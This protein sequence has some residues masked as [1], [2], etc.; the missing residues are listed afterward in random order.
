MTRDN[1]LIITAAICGAEV[2]KEHTPHIPYTAE[3]LASEAER[4]VAAGA[5][6]IHLHVREDDGTPSQDRELFRKAID[7]IRERVGLEP[8]VQVSTGGAVGMSVEER[9]Q[10]LALRPDMAT[11]TTGTVNFGDDVFLND[12][13]SIEAI[14][15][16]IQANHVV[17]E[18]EVFD[19]GMVDTS[20]RLIKMGKLTPPLHYDFVMGVPGGMGGTPD[21]LDFV[22]SLI[23]DNCTWTVAGIGRYE[24]PL[25]RKA[26]AEGGHVRVG[27]EDNIFIR[28]GE[29]AEGSAALVQ[30]VASYSREA[31]RPLADPG[32]ARQILGLPPHAHR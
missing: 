20:L 3:E 15:A 14:L 16:E 6:I 1:P 31:G 23:P 21:R 5:S 13:A 18:I 11:L 4:C 19:T 27:L 28:K 26:I 12:Q 9:C 24:L 17:P 22:K 30:E 10:P 32:T 7:G 8:I 25:A 2:F 29:L